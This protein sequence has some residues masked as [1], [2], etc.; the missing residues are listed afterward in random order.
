MIA[1]FFGWCLY[2][3]L[4]TPPRHADHA[5]IFSAG[6]LLGLLVALGRWFLFPVF[7]NVIVLY[8]DFRAGGRRRG[9]RAV[10]EFI[11]PDDEERR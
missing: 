3:E 6:V 5:T 8:G 11:R 1:G 7:Q 9:D 2:M 10:E 4:A